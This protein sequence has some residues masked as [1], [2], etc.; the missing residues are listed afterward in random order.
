[1][2]KTM[3]ALAVSAAA[4]ATGANASELYNQ[5]GTFSRNGWSCR[6]SSY[7][8]KMAKLKTKHEFVLTS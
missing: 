6:S 4:L 2:N 8:C 3:I 5:D 7:L 1:M